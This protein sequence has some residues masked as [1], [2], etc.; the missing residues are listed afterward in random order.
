ML[1]FG[2]ILKFTGILILVG[3][4]G[5]GASLPVPDCTKDMPKIAEGI[6]IN[7]LH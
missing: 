5:G 2:S 1:W 4:R 6:S 3:L 7:L